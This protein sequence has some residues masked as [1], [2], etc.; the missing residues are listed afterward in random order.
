MFYSSISSVGTMGSGS[1][2]APMIQRV[3]LPS[4]DVR[5]TFNPVSLYCELIMY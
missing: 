1:D 2:Y 4:C 5:Y 3:G